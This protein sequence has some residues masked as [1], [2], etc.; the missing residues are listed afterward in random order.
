LYATNRLAEAE[1]LK[2]RALAILAQFK[3]VTGYTHPRWQA[4]VD[5]HTALLRAMGRSDEQILAILREIAPEL[6]PA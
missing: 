5:N 6:F 2:F 1:P 3:R 4:F